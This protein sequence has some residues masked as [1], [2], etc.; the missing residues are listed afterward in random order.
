MV[1]TGFSQRAL[2]RKLGTQKTL[3]GYLGTQALE[4]HLV[5][6][7]LEALGRSK[8]R[9]AFRQLGTRGTQDILSSQL[10]CQYL[11]ETFRL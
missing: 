10:D 11:L 8:S 7:A 1:Q 2:K 3:K 6:L 9:D 4:R 5:T